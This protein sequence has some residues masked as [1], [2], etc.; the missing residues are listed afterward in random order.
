KIIA[1][2]LNTAVLKKIK[3]FLYPEKSSFP[4]KEIEPHWVWI[5]R[6]ILWIGFGLLAFWILNYFIAEGENLQYLII[7]TVFALAV[8]LPYQYFL[9]KTIQLEISKD[10]LIIQQGLWTQKT[11]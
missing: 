8:L 9:Y 10:F 1:P 6:R 3:S 7:L 2:G 11:E 5:N 4:S